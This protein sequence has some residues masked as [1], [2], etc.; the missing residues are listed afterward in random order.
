MSDGAKR[1][2]PQADEKN[3]IET[4]RA[5]KEYLACGAKLCSKDGFCRLQAGWQTAHRG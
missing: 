2:H 1:L 3:R 4:S 5:G